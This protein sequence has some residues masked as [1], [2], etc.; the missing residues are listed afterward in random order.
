MANNPKKVKDPT[1]VALSA[2]QEALN[3]SDV[4]AGDSARSSMHADAMPP[5]SPAAPTFDEG[6]FDSR[7]GSDR[8]IFAPI[9]EPRSTRRAAND[10]RETIG[11]ILQALQKGR[12]ARGMF[13]TA[14]VVA[15]VW[16]VG[17]GLLTFAFM[18][19]L[20]SALGQSGGVLVL[21]APRRLVL[22]A[23]DVVLFPRQPRLAR[24]GNAH[25]RAVDG[26]GCD[27]LLGAGGR[28]LRLDG[29]RRPGDP[30]RSRGDGRWRRAR[31]RARRR[32]RNPGRQRGR[33]AGARLQRQ[34]GAH[35]R[36]VAGHRPS[37]R[38]PGR[39]GR[40]GAQ[41]DFRRADR[42]A[43]RYRADLGCDRLARRRSRQKHHRRAG[44]ARRPHHLGAQ[45]RR[46]QHDPG[47]RRARRRPA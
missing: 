3:I 10:D 17:C 44:R 19:S 42:P 23:G 36:A 12:P 9:D 40:A 31:D 47:A 27:P 8:A 26:A 30:P 37:A 43:P 5:A 46:R 21:A 11:Q 16:I 15:A 18:S 2:I 38:Q 35:P 34:R 13:T 4:S 14:T 24:P 41:R 1:E 32:T 39:P 29:H 22:C 20:Q 6:T 45:Q 28:R 25:D 7:P 33:R